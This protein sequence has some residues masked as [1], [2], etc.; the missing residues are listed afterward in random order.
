MNPPLTTLFYSGISYPTFSALP[1]SSPQNETDSSCFVSVDRLPR[2]V[3][4]RDVSACALLGVYMCVS[5]MLVYLMPCVLCVHVQLIKELLRDG[6]HPVTPKN[7][8]L[9]IDL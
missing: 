5:G 7:P 3:C 9:H 1:T 8:S 4:V 6:S 2:H